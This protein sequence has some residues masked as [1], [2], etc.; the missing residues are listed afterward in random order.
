[1]LRDATAEAQTWPEPLAYEGWSAEKIIEAAA[2]RDFAGRVALVSS[3]GA[4]SVVLLHLVAQVDRSIPVLFGQTQMLFP[5]T[6]AYQAEVADRL[7]LTDVRHMTPDPVDLAA[8]DPV[9]R[10]HAENPDACCDIRKVR[11]LEKALGGFDAWLNGRKRSQS[12]TRAGLGVVERDA[13]GRAKINPLADWSRDEV[14]AYMDRFNLPLHPLVSRGYP[15]IGC[16]PCT[17]PVAPG[18]SP[19]AGRWRGRSKDECGIHV[20]DGRVVR[21]PTPA[22]TGPFDKV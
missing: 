15:S 9:G 4:E 12:A 14:R 3:F 22:A 17:T 19:R 5:E 10:L 16:L 13:A 6:L 21:M 1:M 7:G 18:E 2:L 11:P 8:A 20:V